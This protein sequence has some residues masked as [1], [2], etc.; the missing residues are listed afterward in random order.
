M[1]AGCSASL[2]LLLS[3]S[4]LLGE[5]GRPYLPRDLVTN[6][7]SAP[8]SY[9]R[10]FF[11]LGERALFLAGSNNTPGYVVWSSDGTPEG[12][13]PVVEFC[14]EGWSG[15]FP[16]ATPIVGAVS[17]AAILVEHCYGDNWEQRLWRSDGTRSGTWRLPVERPLV[18][19]GNEILG[20]DLP[21]TLGP[22][23]L[24]A[25]RSDS[26]APLELWATD[27]SDS[28]TAP[29]ATLAVPSSYFVRLL[30]ALDDFALVGL[31]SF[32][33]QMLELWR[34][35]GTAGGT[36]HVG[37]IP[38]PAYD[39]VLKSTGNRLFFVG[40]LS[41]GTE[42]WVSDGTTSGTVPLT[43]FGHSQSFRTSRPLRGS[44][45]EVFFVGWRQDTAEQIWRSDGTIA[46]TFPLSSFE[47]SAALPDYQYQ[48]EV[49]RLDAAFYFLGR[50]TDGSLSLW[51][52]PASAP[53]M[54][55]VKVVAPA[56]SYSAEPPWIE[57]SGDRLVFPGMDGSGWEIYGSDGTLAGT[58]RLADS[59][60]GDCSGTP[61]ELVLA[62]EFLLFTA[63][64]ESGLR[65]LW[66]TDGSRA[67]TRRVAGELHTTDSEFS[68]DRYLESAR[69]GTGW[70]YRARDA[71]HG[72]EPWFVEGT[73]S[74]QVA[75]LWLDTPGLRVHSATVRGRELAFS[76]YLDF[77]DDRGVYYSDGTEAGSVE[78]ART[79]RCS[80][81][82]V[83]ATPP[84]TTY[85]TPTGFLFDDTDTCE[86][87][88]LRSWNE[89]TGELLRLFASD[90]PT[91]PGSFSVVPHG[92]LLAVRVSDFERPPEI[93][94]TDGTE[95]GTRLLFADPDSTSLGL[96]GSF[97][98][99]I[100]VARS[101]N[102]STT[103]GLLA[104]HG[105]VSDL[106]TLPP[107]EYLLSWEQLPV[108]IGSRVFFT[109]YRSNSPTRFWASDGTRAGTIEFL[110]LPEEFAQWRTFFD[111]NDV[112]LFS[113][114][115][116]DTGL[117]LWKSDGSVAGTHLVAGFPGVSSGSAFE[118]IGDVA[119]FAINAPRPYPE[120]WQSQLW[121]SDGTAGGT[122]LVT[123]L[124][125]GGQ[126]ATVAS[127]Q[128]HGERLLLETFD[129]GPE[130]L[131]G[132]FVSDGTAAGT[133]LIWTDGSGNGTPFGSLWPTS[134][135]GVVVFTAAVPERGEELMISEGS[136]AT[137]RLLADLRPGAASSFP[138]DLRVAGDR[139]YFTADDGVHGRELWVMRATAGEPCV[140]G[141]TVLCLLA[142][143]FSVSMTG[144]GGAAAARPLTAAA[145]AFQRPGELSPDT[146]VKMIDGSGLNARQWLFAA[147]LVD[148]GFSLRV[149][150]TASGI[151]RTWIG[152]ESE[153]SSFGDISAFATFP[154][155]TSVELL[156]AGLA[157][158]AGVACEPSDRRLCFAGGRIAV[159]AAS[160]GFD[161]EVRAAFASPVAIASDEGAFYFFAPD[162]LEL[163]VRVRE[164]EPGR[165]SLAVASLTNLGYALSITDLA[166]GRSRT[167]ES[168]AGTFL[169]QAVDDLFPST[170]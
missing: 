123:H 16:G 161:G 166:T 76:A 169:S 111:L 94:T 13:E 121:R 164:M 62:D 160:L 105:G 95:E 54:E 50:E 30:V 106:L 137:T 90:H 145:G 159:D 48:P 52:K 24:F 138:R 101:L 20:D 7:E 107:D 69:I 71:T 168:P 151:E 118:R 39:G 104:S 100:L 49:V 88:S 11:S 127:L 67:G 72:F 125:A 53:T 109:T 170:P 37:A 70:L 3:S 26:E 22:R 1:R 136:P 147:D 79:R 78:V 33:S 58:L 31:Q 32:D 38:P 73:S 162:T 2:V 156:E 47:N 51:K 144:A 63:T 35:D 85:P 21:Q 140:A 80:C 92:D 122:E 99:G 120:P 45:D 77:E 42:L 46:G 36:M 27:A 103:L 57:K 113:T 115:A 108:Q 75:D 97:L 82:L 165:Y 14:A 153:L 142:G 23:F 34:T 132:L 163:A 87:E 65:R 29:F 133:E 66:S 112:A 64:D 17:G 131:R 4:P 110:T 60:P 10:L 6:L 8:G 126:P 116:W 40:E 84:P 68:S 5:I 135:A 28:G 114:S 143:R 74:R 148:P 139:L 98:G 83:C 167:I 124:I 134:Y 130:S 91:R 25:A 158:Q 19:L 129:S 119:Y 43:S 59:C 93:W 117:T 89:T 152:A 41:T 150:D 154:V 15:Q 141:P 55:R 86:S 12:T 146:F 61:A 9:P 81:G 128:R 155:P 56:G 44:G 102:G 149:V 18:Y 157:P 96:I